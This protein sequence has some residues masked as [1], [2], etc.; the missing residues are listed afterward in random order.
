MKKQ[1]L[2]AICTRTENNGQQADMHH[3][4]M[5]MELN[6]QYL[7]SMRAHEPQRPQTCSAACAFADSL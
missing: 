1:F 2:L 5:C 6:A 3:A 7:C 4:H